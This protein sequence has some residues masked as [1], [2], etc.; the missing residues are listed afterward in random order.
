[1]QRVNPRV[2]EA[3]VPVEE[4]LREIFFPA[5][6]RGLSEGLPKRENTR[7]PV[8]Q[9]GLAPPDPVHM[10]SEN[11]TTSSVI[12]RHLVAALRGQV[13]F[14]TADHLACLQGGRLSVWHRGEKRAEGAL[15]A[16]L[17]G[18]PVLQ[19]RRI[20]QAAKTGAWL[21]VLPSTVKGT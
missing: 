4:A 7:L 10:D 21:T 6:F 9:A 11:W 17:E 2:G 13:V 8:K 20:R 15:T 18:V 1:M 3:F 19:A 14:R 12:T 5:L 16:A